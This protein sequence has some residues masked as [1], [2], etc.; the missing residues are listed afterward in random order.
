[1][2]GTCFGGYNMAMAVMSPC[3]LLQGHWGGEVLIVSI[4][5]V[6]LL[7]LRT[8][9]LCTPQL[10]ATAWESLGAA[11]SREQSLWGSP[12]KRQV[13]GVPLPHLRVEA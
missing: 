10:L 12:R 13:G 7:P 6:G 2:L 3:P 8:P 9:Q 1:M 5:P 4:R 11:L